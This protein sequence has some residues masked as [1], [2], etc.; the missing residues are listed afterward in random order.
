MVGIEGDVWRQEYDRSNDPK[1]EP[2]PIELNR[3]II[4]PVAP[5]G[6]LTFMR[7]PVCLT[8]EDL[9][10][11]EI[12]VAVIGAPL[13]DQTLKRNYL[14]DIRLAKRTSGCISTGKTNCPI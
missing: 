8:P 6:I 10:A 14:T 11:G 12:D 3:Y 13:V 7:W 4:N 1:R 5:G 2:G 9:K